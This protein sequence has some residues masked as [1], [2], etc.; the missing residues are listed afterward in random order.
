MLF[1]A[2]APNVTAL[3]KGI[4]LAKKRVEELRQAG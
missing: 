3:I 4:E 2:G 1:S